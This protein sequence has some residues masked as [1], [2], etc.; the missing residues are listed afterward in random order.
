MNHYPRLRV[1]QIEKEQR[2]QQEAKKIVSV[3][4]PQGNQKAEN[5]ISSTYGVEVIK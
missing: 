5:H 4:K 1:F 2:Q 3:N